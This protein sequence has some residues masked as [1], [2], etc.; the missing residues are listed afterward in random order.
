VDFG[1]LGSIEVTGPEGTVLLPGPK[2][3][4]LV[5]LPRRA[6]C[7]ARVARPPCRRPRGQTSLPRRRGHGSDLRVLVPQTLRER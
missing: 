2:R 5:G 6:C 4:G 3:R 1:I 7:A